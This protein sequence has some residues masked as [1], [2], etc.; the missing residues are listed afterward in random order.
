MRGEY[1]GRLELPLIRGKLLW[2]CVGKERHGVCHQF[3]K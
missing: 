2:N 1:D 3:P